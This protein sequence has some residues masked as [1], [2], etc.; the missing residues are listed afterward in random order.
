L[1][2]WL[3]LSAGLLLVVTALIILWPR[4]SAASH[5]DGSS[6]EEEMEPS[7]PVPVVR[8]IRPRKNLPFIIEAQQPADVE[9]FYRADMMALVAGFVKRVPKGINDHVRKGELLVEVDVPD[10]VQDV[11]EKEAVVRQRVREREVT[12]NKAEI[13]DAAVKVAQQTIK[14]KQADVLVADAEKDFR[15]DELKRYQGLVRRGVVTPD[16]AAEK[17]KYYL[18][19]ESASI[20]ARVA[21]QKAIADLEEEKAKLRAA[22][23]DIKLKEGL[24]EV[25]GQDLARAMALADYAKIRAPFDGKIIRRDVDPG[26]FV[27]NAATGR[28]SSLLALVRTDIMTVVMK[29]PDNYAPYVTKD[30]NAIIQVPGRLIRAKVT[31]YSPSIHEKDRTMR[32]E[33]D[34][35]N[36]S[37]KN[38]KRFVAKG[39][40]TFLPAVTGPGPVCNALL[41]CAGRSAW[42]DN[43]KTSMDPFPTFPTRVVTQPE[44]KTKHLLPRMYGYMTLLLKDFQNEYL[45]PNR[46]VFSLGGK[47]YILIVKDHKAHRI[48]VDV[49]V[50]DARLARVFLLVH[51]TLD[52]GEIDERHEL[53]GNEEIVV[54]GQTEIHEG[55][56][57]Q[58]R[59][60][61]WPTKADLTKEQ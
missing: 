60:L 2:V 46:A 24:I 14:Q 44:G 22:R 30:T 28:S 61:A 38:Y 56:T 17:K 19:A 5:P 4:P 18:A 53:A 8:T 50:H 49:Q 55:Q 36:Q 54:T 16:V 13:A 23:A 42:S 32:V 29:L 15:A 57:V 10:R 12:E 7:E 20:S 6:A 34:L 47:S 9:P 40:S 51:K 45:I 43:M 31:R 11:L 35:Y 1:L 37:R 58:A 52:T 39:L 27:H 26:A 33:V 59:P 3:G 41:L 48:P 21:V 25:A